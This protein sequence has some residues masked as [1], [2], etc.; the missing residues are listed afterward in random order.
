MTSEGQKTA[1]Q[2]NARSPAGPKS[3]AGKGAVS[4][5]PSRRRS[6]PSGEHETMAL[7]K[8]EAELFLEAL[9]NPPKMNAK[10]AKALEEHGRR[11]VRR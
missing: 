11:V 7:G 4:R 9:A 8:R 5:V 6:R 1:N 10:L 2:A 3:A